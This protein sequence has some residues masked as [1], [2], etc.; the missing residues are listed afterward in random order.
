LK[1]GKTIRPDQLS[2]C[3]GIIGILSSDDNPPAIKQTFGY[4]QVIVLARV[5]LYHTQRN[6]N[7]GQIAYGWMNFS[8][9]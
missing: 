5:L 7:N 4:Q 6:I 2:V 9:G 3:C 8:Q 1:N